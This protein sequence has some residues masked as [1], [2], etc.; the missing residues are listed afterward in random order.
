M[1]GEKYLKYPFIISDKYNLVLSFIKSL[2]TKK[3][4]RIIIFTKSSDF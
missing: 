4:E 2:F 3:K 1:L